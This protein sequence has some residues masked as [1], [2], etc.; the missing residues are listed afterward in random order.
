[1]TLKAR[2]PPPR[3]PS[4]VRAPPSGTYLASPRLLA[5]MLPARLLALLVLLL[6]PR[7]AS[8]VATWLSRGTAECWTAALKDEHFAWETTDSMVS[9]VDGLVVVNRGGEMILPERHVK[10]NV[11]EPDGKVVYEEGNVLSEAR[12]S[13]PSHGAGKYEICVHNDGGGEFV[14]VEL[15]YFIPKHNLDLPDVVVAPNGN[16]ELREKEVAT[17]EHMMP[18]YGHLVELEHLIEEIADE[19]KSLARR[20]IRHLRTVASSNWRTLFYAGLEALVF[21]AC[22]FGQVAVIRGLFALRNNEVSRGRG[23]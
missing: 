6:L 16:K 7:D 20:Q 14:H 12:F 10:I 9:T 21:A 4:S 23:V 5:A 17:K 18:V 1:M 15:V 3:E 11:T 8:A 22:T 19:Q 2:R 13:V